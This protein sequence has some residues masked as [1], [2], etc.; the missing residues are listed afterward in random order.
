[1]LSV[2]AVQYI[3]SGTVLYPRSFNGVSNFTVATSQDEIVL[4]GPANEN[5]GAVVTY[6]VTA[7]AGASGT[8][9]LGFLQSSSLGTWMLALNPEQCAYYGE[10][11]AG[12][13][14][15]NY[16]QQLGGCITYNT[17]YFTTTTVSGITYPLLTNNIY[18]RILGVTNSTQ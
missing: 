3:Q 6:A 4:G 17:T 8:Y 10:L 18:F 12:N 9:Q 14:Q 7:I 13:G 1:M 5:E 16:A 15:P 2:E 11:V